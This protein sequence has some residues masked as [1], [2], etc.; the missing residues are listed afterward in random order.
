MKL[1]CKTMLLG[2]S[3]VYILNRRCQLCKNTPHMYCCL[4]PWKYNSGFRHTVSLRDGCLPDI[5]RFA[6]SALLHKTTALDNNGLGLPVLYIYCTNGINADLNTTFT[7]LDL[8]STFVRGALLL[9]HAKKHSVT[10]EIGQQDR[11]NWLT[12][13]QLTHV[14]TF[15]L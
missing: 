6:E 10:S 7:V 15:G 13:K 14:F 12:G 9:A 3:N 5:K 11:R 4:F 2:P 8:F 1:I